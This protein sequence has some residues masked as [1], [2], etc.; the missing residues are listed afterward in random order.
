MPPPL[1]SPTLALSHTQHRYMSDRATP[2]DPHH[3]S[4][5]QR[6]ALN[7][8]NSATPSI[9]VQ[10]HDLGTPES[11]KIRRMKFEIEIESP[12]KRRARSASTSVESPRKLGASSNSRSESQMGHGIG[13]RR[14]S[15]D[16]TGHLSSPAPP[17]RSRG[18]SVSQ[19]SNGHTASAS[20]S[21]P[22][23]KLPVTF[24]HPHP[25]PLDMTRSPTPG[26]ISSYYLG[27]H[28]GR[29]S[30][31]FA[32]LLE[33]NRWLDDGFNVMVPKEE[34]PVG[35]PGGKRADLRLGAF[36]DG[37]KREKDGEFTVA[38]STSNA[39]I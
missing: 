25:V 33:S 14:W 19:D 7:R 27:A 36:V 32:P 12:E 11:V 34:L 30:E 39:E 31:D 22:R 9:V 23:I 13:S 28:S 4:L 1:P 2:T 3:P 29:E 17:G 5:S 37:A 24:Q 35:T 6:P 26:S 16:S 20:A 8:A 10:H 15:A 18:S 21:C 38:S